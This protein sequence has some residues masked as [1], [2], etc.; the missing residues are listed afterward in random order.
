M[1]RSVGKSFTAD[2]LQLVRPDHFIC[3]CSFESC[4]SNFSSI[5]E[6]NCER[7]VVSARLLC[8]SFLRH[9]LCPSWEAE[10]PILDRQMLQ[11]GSFI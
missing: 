4:L 8:K 3:V 10:D 11:L 7:G 9:R 5:G 6:V 2:L 1:D